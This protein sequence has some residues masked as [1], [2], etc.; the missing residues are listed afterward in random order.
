MSQQV[1]IDQILEPIV[2]PWIQ[3]RQ[4]FFSGED[5]DLGHG[6]GKSSIVRTWHEK[7]GLESCFNCHN[8]PDFAPNLYRIA[9]CPE[10][11]LCTNIRIGVRQLQKS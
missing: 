2:K 11:R 7:N 1:Y 10:N 6:H 8:Y 3:A 9:D 5:G 4:D